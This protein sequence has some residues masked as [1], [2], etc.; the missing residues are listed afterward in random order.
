MLSQKGTSRSPFVRGRRGALLHIPGYH[1]FLQIHHGRQYAVF[2]AREERSGRPLVIKTIQQGPSESHA[3]ATLLHEHALLC[4]LEIPGVVRP[5]KLEEV[6]G[7]PALVLEDAGPLDLEQHLG[8]KQLEIELVL[9]LAIQVVGIVQ[10]LHQQNVIHRDINPSN[11]VVRPDTWTLTLIDFGTATKATGV[12]GASEGTLSYIAPEQTGRMNRLVDHRADLYSIG[13]TLYE[14]LTGVP[15]FVSAD[16]VE[17]IHAQ[18]ARPPVPPSQL[19][20][21][22]P[23]VLSDIVLKL[24]AKMPEERYQSAESL[25]LDLREAQRQWKDSGTIAPF[26]LALHDRAREL[27]IPDKLYGREQELSQLR[28][29]LKRVSSGRS[30]VILVTGDAGSGKSA[31]VHEMRRQHEQGARFLFGKFDQL[32]GNVPYASLEKALGG[33]VNNLL[34]EPP[35]ALLSWRQ[36]LQDALGPQGCVMTRFIPELARLLG[37]QPPAA[38]QGIKETESRFQLSFQAFIQVFA[39]RECPLVLFMDDMQW[40]DTGSL[41]LLRSLAS[42]KDLRHVLFIGAYRSREVG[43]DH[44][45]PQAL[46]AMHSAGAALRTLE[47]PPLGLPALTQLCSDILQAEPGNVGPLAELLLRK[48]AGNPFFIKR[49]L[50]FLHAAGLLTFDAEQHAWRW[51]LARIEQV[52]VTENVVELLLPAIRRLPELTQQLLKVAAC[53]RDRVDLWLL[54]A[55]AETSVLDTAGAL[56]SAV[57]EGLLVA[58]S[59]GPRFAHGKSG[60]LQHLPTHSATYSFAH[61]RIQQA[62]Y[63]LLSDEESRRIH[64]RVGHQLL[65]GISEQELD[66]RIFEVVDHFDMGRESS[67]LLEP[68]E[69][70][71]L[72]G[73][74]FRA[75]S[76]A[77]ATSAFSSALIYLRQGL[78]LLTPEA[79]QSHHELTFQLHLQAAQC[80]HIIGDHAFAEA[81]IQAARPHVASD[82]EELSLYEIHVVAY[83][84]ARNYPE[85][86]RWGRAG[87]RLLGEELPR[88]LEQ[89]FADEATAVNEHLRD[90]TREELLAGPS[91]EDPQLIALMRLVSSISM[92]AWFVDQPLFFFLEAWMVHLS[93]ERG[94]S[95]YSTHAYVSHGSVL[96]TTT[97]NSR[98]GV[99]L[100]EVGVELS[101]RYGDQKEECRCLQMF[102]GFLNHWRAPYRTSVPLTR[103]A[104]A[105]GLAGNE[106]LFGSYAVTFIAMIQYHMGTELSVTLTET[107]NSLV[108]IQKI[109]HRDMEATLLAY[110]QAIRCLQARTHQRA[111]FDD[112]TFSEEEYLESIRKSP[113]VVCEYQ[114]LRIQTSYLL[115]EIADAL[116]LSRVV[117]ENFQLVRPFLMG[118]DYIFYTALTLAAYHPEAPS[119]EKNSVLSQLEEHLNLLDTWAQDCPENFRHKH[120]LVAAELARL[121]GRHREAMLL[122]DSA[123]D[124]AHQNEFPQDEALANNLAG[125]LYRS[126]GHRRT[127]SLYLQAAMRGFARWGARAKSAALEDAFPDLTLGEALPWKL[128]A[129]REGEEARGI[130]LDLLSI[131]KA[132]ETLSSEVVLDRLLEKLMTI[133][134]EV[135]GAERGALLLHEEDALFVRAVSTTSEPV[136]LERTPLQSSQHVPRSMLARAYSSGEAIILADASRSP[137]ASD[138]Y[139]ASR[140]LKSALAVPIRRKASSV[141]VLYLENNL[142]TR[143]FAPDRVQVLQ[144]L[145][146]QMA[147]SLENSFLFE[148]RLRAESAVRFLAESSMALAES[149]DYEKTLARVARIA[150]PFLADCCMVLMQD[151]PQSVRCAA[152]T[153]ATPAKEALLRESERRYPSCWGSQTPGVVALRTRE[154][155]LIPEVSDEHLLTFSQE[156][157]HRELMRSLGIR[158]C[159]AVPLLSGAGSIGSISFFRMSRK[160]RYGPADLALAHELARRAVMSIDNARLFRDAQEAIHLRDEF[161]SIASHELYTP[162]TSLQLSLQRLERTPA[163]ASS[164]VT[165]RVFQNTW[166]QMRRLRRLLDELLS[167]SRLQLNPMH[168]QLEEVDLAAITRDIVEHFSEDSAH[169]SSRLLLNAP[170]RV[171]GRWDRIRIEQVVTNLLANAI[172]F[173]NRKPIELSVSTEGDSA[174]LTVQDHGIGIAPD[175]LP[176]IFERFERAVSA[177]EYGGLGLGLYI[178]RE[179]V[180]AL[181]GTIRVDSTPGAGTRFTVQLP[182]AGPSHSAEGLGA[183]Q[184][185]DY[186]PASAM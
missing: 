120:Q 19:N 82:L 36:R 106:F 7:A 170:P 157:A 3:T 155:Q 159:M 183:G 102:S 72:A 141:G 32:H 93:L 99:M 109:G 73:L 167:V 84:F 2:R 31:L 41:H 51:E 158:S 45:L 130:R 142:A 176:H 40:A 53:F 55:V 153:C 15:P 122:Y 50:R 42:A 175:K 5:I 94:H 98:T 156:G 180:S 70:L 23:K 39:T 179:I 18:L 143:A 34:R 136:S 100:G 22:V 56:W 83:I 43:P 24:L 151:K 149:L 25:E 66:E 6:A 112:D 129:T 89:A 49:L 177:R 46:G 137:F 48:T 119:S 95:L 54:S 162:L 173:G 16:P 163:T 80:A 86:I 33:L 113:L 182:R 61:D 20:P 65:K 69:R 104:I 67:R 96:V 171:I 128:P 118:I 91:T 185:M 161:L 10:A 154:S 152:L 110:R 52:E 107:E 146:S 108:F 111:G 97:G 127:A 92:A 117:G 38:P 35:P 26:V 145:S 11:F 140:A 21:S 88:N 44:P 124:A 87:L 60:T 132:A 181:G 126:L 134:L 30:E 178:V 103:R 75:G 165:S 135:A 63:S 37:E 4:G 139:V 131:L 133:C 59:Q 164:E 27:V 57:Q 114:V 1:D 125:C 29:A 8:Q 79:W 68:S 184:A 168:L 58:Q 78:A 160:H 138:P 9:K 12:V 85:A 13:A 186:E 174:L 71:Q 14:L 105:L 147:I 62:V 150:V 166:R 47:V 64:R 169:S 76:R 17:L 90:R 115:G 74:Y 101:R 81:L 77:E 172:K 123:I 144:L 116:E 121:E 148:E 28:R